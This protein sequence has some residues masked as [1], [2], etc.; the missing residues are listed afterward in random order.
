MIR[1]WLILWLSS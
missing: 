1:D